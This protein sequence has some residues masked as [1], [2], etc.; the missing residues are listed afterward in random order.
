MEKKWWTL[1]V[2]CAA[3]FMLLLDVTIVVVALP[4]IQR[5]LHTTFADVQWVIDAYA[6]TLASLLL[7]SGSLADRY[8]RKLL[9]VIGLSIFTL[10]SLTCG[11]AQS[12][13][14]LIVSRA[15]QGVGGAILFATS[16]ALLAQNFQGRERGIAFGIWGAI[17]GVAVALGPILGGVITSGINWRGIFLVNIPVGAVAL[18]ITLRTVSESRSPSPTRP[19]WPGFASLTAGLVSLVYGLI[20]ASETSWSNTAVVVCLCLGGVLLASFL[21][22]ESRVARP[23]FDLSLLRTPTFSGGSI[24]AFCMNGSLYAML[25]YFVLYLQYDLGYSALDTGL[26][27]LLMSGT[28]LVAATISGRLSS[29]VPVRWLIGP[30][31]FLVGIGLIT[32]TGLNGSSGWTHLIPGF[33][34]G[35]IGGGLVNPPLAST[36]VG[37]VVPQRAGMASGVNT[38]FRQIGIAVGIAAYGSI[39]TATLQNNLGHRLGSVPGFAGRASAVASAIKQGTVGQLI[40]SLHGRAQ[41]E[42]VGAVRSAFAGS[43]ND[44]VVV[45]GILAIVGAIGAASLIRSK[46]FASVQPP[47]E[48]GAAVQVEPTMVAGH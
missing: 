46:D 47:A 13:L 15:A 14:M 21:V 11:L 31:L 32:M 41:G 18:A 8:G 9:F 24:A 28:T 39:F 12:P 6:L 17:T 34:L 26:M 35:G 29:Q 4:E 48:P 45:S 2:V 1:T 20:H 5:G 42:L 25:V 23:M 30:G 7:T 27:L 40:G 3:T 37:V 19:D 38:T 22:I 43:L 16:L 44:L 10:G 36:A 33:L